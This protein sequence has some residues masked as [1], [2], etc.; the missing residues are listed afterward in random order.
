MAKEAADIEV[1]KVLHKAGLQ[2]GKLTTPIEKVIAGW[3][4]KLNLSECDPGH[5][6]VYETMLVSFEAMPPA[7]DDSSRHALR[8]ELLAL[9]AEEV[10][11]RGGLRQPREEYPEPPMF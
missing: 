10:R 9:L 8:R 1:G 2:M 3:R 4:N 5:R 7:T 6:W 11:N